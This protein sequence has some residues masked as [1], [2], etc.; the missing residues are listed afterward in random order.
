MREASVHSAACAR[1]RDE[2]DAADN[3]QSPSEPR[4]RMPQEGPDCEQP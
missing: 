1:N 4:E 3:P 2:R